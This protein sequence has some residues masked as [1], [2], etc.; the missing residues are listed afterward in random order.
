MPEPSP[1]RLGPSFLP[2]PYSAERRAL[3]QRADAAGRGVVE[4]AIR[5]E[6]PTERIARITLQGGAAV[7]GMRPDASLDAAVEALG[8]Y[9]DKRQPGYVVPV[10]RRGDLIKILRDAGVIVQGAADAVA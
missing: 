5:E 6:T 7:A 1:P 9:Y 8:G 2:P 10:S 3:E 4:Q